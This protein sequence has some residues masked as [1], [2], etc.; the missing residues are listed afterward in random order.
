MPLKECEQHVIVFTGD[1]LTVPVTVKHLLKKLNGFSLRSKFAV[2]DL[3][4][5]PWHLTPRMLNS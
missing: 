2:I 4:R 3:N 1:I 5:L